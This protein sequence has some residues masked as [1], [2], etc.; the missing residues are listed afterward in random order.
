MASNPSTSGILMSRNSRWRFLAAVSVRA[1]SRSRNFEQFGAV[2]EF[3]DRVVYA[4]PTQRLLQEISVLGFVI[5]DENRLQHAFDSHA[6]KVETASAFGKPIGRVES[7]RRGAPG[8]AFLPS[9]VPFQPGGWTNPA[10][11]A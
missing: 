9:R 10:G 11:T 5:G 3:N 1:A 7:V 4:R 2:T 6:S 8:I